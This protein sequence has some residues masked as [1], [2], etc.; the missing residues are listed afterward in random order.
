[1]SIKNNAETIIESSQQEK[2]IVFNND[3]P[4]NE[5]NINLEIESILL[6]KKSSSIISML[7]N[8]EV[9]EISIIPTNQE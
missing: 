5:S 4:M 9:K 2:K 8:N 3:D 1:M 6:Q 7:A